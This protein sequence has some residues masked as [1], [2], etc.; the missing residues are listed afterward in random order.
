MDAGSG[1]GQSHGTGDLLD[2]LDHCL[3]AALG[4]G[5]H[6]G[7]RLRAGR[8]FTGVYWCPA[9]KLAICV[10]PGGRRGQCVAGPARCFPVTV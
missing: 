1:S 3:V 8:L 5:C 7:D 4:S 10:C 6:G 9:D 2:R